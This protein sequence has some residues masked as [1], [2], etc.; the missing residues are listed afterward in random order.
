MYMLKQYLIAY[1][2]VSGHGW[3][4][5]LTKKDLGLCGLCRHKSVDSKP[6]MSVDL[7]VDYFMSTR[8]LLPRVT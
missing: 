8:E 3:I 1:Y 4:L 2:P 6:F 5:S 7:I